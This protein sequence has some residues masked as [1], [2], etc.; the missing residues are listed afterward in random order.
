MLFYSELILSSQ[1]VLHRMQWYAFIYLLF[2]TKLW[3]DYKENVTDKT[4]LYKSL[5]LMSVLTVLRREGFYLFVVG[6][7]LLLMVYRIQKQERLKYTIIILVTTT[8]VYLPPIANSL[9]STGKVAG[10]DK[11][12]TTSLVL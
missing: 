7:I 10:E 6:T 12:T 3:F 2:L 4:A 9:F 1:M 11:Q 5:F 8:L